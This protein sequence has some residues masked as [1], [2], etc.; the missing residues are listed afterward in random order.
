MTNGRELKGKQLK[1]KRTNP[2]NIRPMHVNDMVVSHDGIEFYITFSEIEPPAHLDED[3]IEKLQTIDA[4][5]KVKLVLSPTFAE[6]TVKVLSENIEKF[7]I[8]RESSNE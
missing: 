2:D 6:A 7:N 5:A 8:K 3:I 1:L 4:V